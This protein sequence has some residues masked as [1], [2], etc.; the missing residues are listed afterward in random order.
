MQTAAAP[1]TLRGALDT[2]KALVSTGAHH[3]AMRVVRKAIDD[4]ILHLD[5]LNEADYEESTKLMDLCR[6]FLTE[7]TPQAE[8][9]GEQAE[10]LTLIPSGLFVQLYD[11]FVGAVV[12]AV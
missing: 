6:S 8:E 5:T 9:T 11:G 3:E 10:G 2:A 12:V 4:A 1:A 7:V